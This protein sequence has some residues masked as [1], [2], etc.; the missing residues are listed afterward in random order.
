MRAA[1]LCW[2][3]TGLVMLVATS[4]CFLFH[5]SSSPAQGDAV[6]V[7]VANDLLAPSQVTVELIPDSGTK[8]TLGLVPP[9]TH[10][11]LNLV[12]APRTG[13]VRLQALAQGAPNVLSP[14][15][16]LANAAAVSW[17]L[18]TNAVQLVPRAPR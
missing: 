6:Y 18:R 2:S 4:S 16:G 8:R 3:A 15:F 5:G 10:Q 17:D 7:Y 12:P 1:R 9:A 14:P 13:Q 11:M